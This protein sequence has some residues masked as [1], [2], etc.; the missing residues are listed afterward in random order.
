MPKPLALYIFG[1]DQQRIEQVTRQT[2][3]GGMCVNHNLLQFAHENLPFG[4]VNHSGIGK[5]HGRFGFEAFSNEKP[6]LTHRFNAMHMLYPPYTARVR[7]LIEFA[8]RK[9]G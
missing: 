1:K 9:L 6:V 7:K 2:S 8:V 3:A 4:G 5:A